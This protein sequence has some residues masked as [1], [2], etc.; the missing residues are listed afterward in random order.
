MEKTLGNTRAVKKILN[1]WNVDTS[2][3]N[4]QTILHYAA[5]HDDPKVALYACDPKHGI[6]LNQ[7]STHELRT[8]LHLGVKESRVE[9][10]RILLENG[11][12]DEWG[13][14]FGMYAEEYIRNDS[15]GVLFKRHG[16]S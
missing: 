6:K 4:N 5:R 15:I 16:F 3:G 13:D 14:L 11:A 7:S 2:S 12:R 8:A 10:T 9:I 1:Y